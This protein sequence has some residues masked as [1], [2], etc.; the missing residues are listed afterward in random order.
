MHNILFCLDENVNFQTKV[1]I[2]SLLENTNKK[3]N[4]F[5]LHK[6]PDSFNLN[7][8]EILNHNSLNNINLIK[9]NLNKENFR[10]NKSLEHVTEA[11]YYRLF[12]ENFLPENLSEILYL[13]T[14]VFCNKNFDSVVF[15][16]FDILKKSK[17]IIGSKTSQIENSHSESLMLSSKKYFNA[18]V[19]FID[20]KKWRENKI[21]SALSDILSKNN[22]KY[23]DQD[24]MNLY[25]DGDYLEIDQYLN[26]N[27]NTNIKHSIKNLDIF[28]ENVIFAHFIGKTKP[29]TLKGEEHPNSYFFQNYARRINNGRIYLVGRKN[30]SYFFKLFNKKL[31]K[32]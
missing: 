32:K 2:F 21:T 14:D 13:D 6:N 4:F 19:M 26:S 8:K 7:E 1:S 9:F 30:I 29:W 17:F 11:T 3:I 18:G 23:M 24:I 25:F 5:I 31:F 28:K 27:V 12:I 10:L 20:L 16:T 15:S 22:F